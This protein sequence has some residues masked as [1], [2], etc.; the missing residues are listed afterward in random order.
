[1]GDE[2]NY[3]KDV[4]R[5]M[6][7]VD[8]QLLLLKKMNDDFTIKMDNCEKEMKEL[9]EKLDKIEKKSEENHKSFTKT[10]HDHYIFEIK[11]QQQ[12]NKK[13]EEINDNNK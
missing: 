11:E 3:I 4:N 6:K 9:K 13:K 8:E 5:I 1:M 12:Q 2:S 10:L 7:I